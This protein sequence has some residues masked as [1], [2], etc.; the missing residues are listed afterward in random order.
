[1]KE[2]EVEAVASAFYGVEHDGARWDCAPELLKEAFRMEA[3]LAIT[4][5]NE[6]YLGQHAYDLY[7]QE[8]GVAP[9]RYLH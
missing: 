4:A 2:D 1:M 7:W 6:H 8:A 3:R 5:C 9:P